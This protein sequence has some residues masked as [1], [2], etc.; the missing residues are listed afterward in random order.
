MSE[1]APLRL[2][3]RERMAR[4]RVVSGISIAHLLANDS[5]LVSATITIVAKAVDPIIGR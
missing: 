2:S 4:S 3:G 5:G 1:G